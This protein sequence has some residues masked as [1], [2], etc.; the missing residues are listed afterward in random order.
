MRACGQESPPFGRFRIP[1][2]ATPHTDCG[3]G[4]PTGSALSEHLPAAPGHSEDSLFHPTRARRFS[5]N[6]TRGFLHHRRPFNWHRFQ[7]EGVDSSGSHRKKKRRPARIFPAEFALEPKAQPVVSNF[8]MAIPKVGRQLALDPQM[9]QL[10]LDR[11]NTPWKKASHII[12][13]YAQSANFM[14]IALCFDHHSLPPFHL[15]PDE[16]PWKTWSEMLAPGEGNSLHWSPS[17]L[18]VTPETPI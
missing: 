2:A 13:A 12:C 7:L 14:P 16:A 9:I 18:A 4:L 6:G 11:W 10:Q 15:Q 1:P 8:R 5:D 3:D 17:D